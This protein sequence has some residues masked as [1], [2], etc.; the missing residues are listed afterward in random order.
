MFGP[1]R[2]F[3]F[4]DDYKSVTC[5]LPT[6]YCIFDISPFSLKLSRRSP[7][8]SIGSVATAAG[9]QFIAFS[10]LPADPE[11]DTKHVYVIN[12]SSETARVLE[13]R[14]TEHILSMR[15]TPVVV[16]L[17]FYRHI[18]LWNIATGCQT[19]EIQTGVNVCAPIDISR[20]FTFMAIPGADQSSIVLSPL[21]SQGGTQLRAADEAVTQVRFSRG[22]ECIAAVDSHGKHVSVFEAG[23]G[24]WI[25]KFKRGP[26]ASVIY[27]VDFSPNCEFI[28]TLSQNGII[29]LFDLRDKRPAK[30]PPTFSSLQKISIG[31]PGIAH[32]IWAEP[33]LIVVITAD[34]IMLLI[35]V[36]EVTCQEVGRE[37]IFVLTRLAEATSE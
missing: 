25:G 37:Q 15:M 13:L 6:H 24:L 28:A 8:L 9:H 2:F 32:L 12:N 35:S 21:A 17:A 36:D 19:L 31:Q 23:K 34:G 33:G 18:E 7:R 26:M 10:G 14:F 29:N 5:V 30:S 20:D 3:C 16:L 1:L 11:F 27:S 4:N 22:G